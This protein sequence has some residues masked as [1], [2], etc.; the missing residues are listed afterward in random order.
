MKGR[1]AGTNGQPRAI[2]KPNQCFNRWR[3]DINSPQDRCQPRA[4]S[5]RRSRL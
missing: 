5:N 2:S 3:I 1:G 4:P